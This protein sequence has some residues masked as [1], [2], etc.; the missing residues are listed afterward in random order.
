MTTKYIINLQI[1]FMNGLILHSKKLQISAVV[2]GIN[3]IT[4]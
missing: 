4:L 1:N 3:T 2:L